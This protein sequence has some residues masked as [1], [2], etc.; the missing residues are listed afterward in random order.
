MEQ[1]EQERIY[2]LPYGQ[3]LTE[4]GAA[5]LF[6]RKYRPIFLQDEKGNITQMNGDEWI[7]RIVADKTEYFYKD[8][9]T[10][11]LDFYTLA[12][13]KKVLADWFMKYRQQKV[14]QLPLPKQSKQG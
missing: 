11:E 13:V 6:D 10:P 4:D 14:S 3:W 8:A 5:V 9:S 7:E 12:K 2:S 1:I